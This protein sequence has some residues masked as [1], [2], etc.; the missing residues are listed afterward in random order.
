MCA[1]DWSRGGSPINRREP[2]CIA[3]GQHINRRSAIGEAVD[4]CNAMIT[5]RRTGGDIVIADGLR[6]LPHLRLEVLI[7]IDAGH[8]LF[9]RPA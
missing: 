7:R 6:E 8:H 9:Y 2:T 3:V 4:E 5:N 1:I